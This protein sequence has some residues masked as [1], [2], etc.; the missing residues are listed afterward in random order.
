MANYPHKHYHYRSGGWAECDLGDKCEFNRREELE[1]PL[2]PGC[3]EGL[4]A[5]AFLAFLLWMVG[6]K[7]YRDQSTQT[8]TASSTEQA[9]E[10]R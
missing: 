1:L 5:L 4:I 6:A 2:K 8:P 10:T 7:L 3:Y 9:I